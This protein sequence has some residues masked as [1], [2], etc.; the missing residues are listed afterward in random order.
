MPNGPRRSRRWL[1]LCTRKPTL[2]SWT[3]WPGCRS[4]SSRRR[5][6]VYARAA[7]QLDPAG[8]KRVL[9]ARLERSIVARQSLEA[10]IEPLGQMRAKESLSLLLAASQS[11]LSPQDRYRIAWALG[12]LGDDRAVP[13]LTG[14]LQGADYQLKEH[15]PDGVGKP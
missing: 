1:A 7:V 3:R 10:E 4:T 14:W 11:S 9:L 12:R 15:G 13:I 5:E 2:R 6:A 8:A